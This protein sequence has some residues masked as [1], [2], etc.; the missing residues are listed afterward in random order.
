MSAEDDALR[1]QVMALATGNPPLSDVEIAQQMNL[2]VKRVKSWTQ[3]GIPK[4]PEAERARVSQYRL[5][6]RGQ[7]S[8]RVS[9]LSTDDQELQRQSR[10]LATADPPLADAEIAELIGQP[11][12]RVAKWN[13]RYIRTLPVEERE[14]IAAYRRDFKMATAKRIGEGNRK[15]PHGTQVDIAVAILS[16]ERTEDVAARYGIARTHALAVAKSVFGEEELEQWTQGRSERLSRAAQLGYERTPFWDRVRNVA[17]PPERRRLLFALANRL[18]GSQP[19][20]VARFHALLHSATEAGI[21]VGEA[22]P[23]MPLGVSTPG[24]A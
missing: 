10:E 22:N 6:F 9:R 20:V 4:L 1:Q 2:P 18:A 14:R 16:G 19:E 24:V 3:R 15:I 13:S 17:T 8:R 23:G 11:V 12:T 5:H 21:D 7:S